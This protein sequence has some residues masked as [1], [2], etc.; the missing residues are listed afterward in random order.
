M[1]AGVPGGL[2]R[3][4]DRVPDGLLE[5]RVEGL[6]GLL[7]GPTLIHLR[8]RRSPGLFVSVLLHG[9]EDTG[10]YAAQALLRQTLSPQ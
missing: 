1:D 10:F 4:L 3:V 8:G 6:Y 7:G 5:A 2:L 9:N